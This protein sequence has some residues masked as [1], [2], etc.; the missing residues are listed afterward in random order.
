MHR[1]IDYED[2]HDLKSKK[3]CGLRSSLHSLKRKSV[4]TKTMQTP[5]QMSAHRMDESTEVCSFKRSRASSAKFMRPST[6]KSVSDFAK[7]VE[8]ET[9]KTIYDKVIS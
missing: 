9:L 4:L 1:S 7:F 2:L 6:L 5:E 8:K 3:D